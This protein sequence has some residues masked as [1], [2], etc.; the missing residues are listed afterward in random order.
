[1]AS[2]M[3]RMSRCLIDN[4]IQQE[5]AQWTEIRN[6]ERPSKPSLL[7]ILRDPPGQHDHQKNDLLQQ[8]SLLRHLSTGR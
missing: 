4:Q 3:V 2:H 1:M 5:G 6:V 7:S 8:M